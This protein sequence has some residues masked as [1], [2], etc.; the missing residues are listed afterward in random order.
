MSEQTTKEGRGDRQLGALTPTEP[1]PGCVGLSGMDGVGPPGGSRPANWRSLRHLGKVKTTPEK[2]AARRWC[3]V[4]DEADA[5]RGRKRRMTPAMRAAAAA[6]V[7]RKNAP[8]LVP[9][10]ECPICLKKKRLIQDHSYE[11]G[12]CRAR[13]CVGCNT[14]L[15]RYEAPPEETQRFLDYIAQWKATHAAGIGRPYSSTTARTPEAKARSTA[16]LT[17]QRRAKRAKSLE[18]MA[19][20][21]RMDKTG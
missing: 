12:R 16:R 18:E 2:K 5:A 20:A 1:A 4:M 19:P 10:G 13:I 14:K 6:A 21:H 15:G 3:D 9:V 17:E 7:G 8:W 11:T